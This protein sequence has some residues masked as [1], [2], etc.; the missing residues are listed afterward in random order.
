[1]SERVP[2]SKRLVLVTV[3][4]NVVTHA[5]RVGILLWVL[6]YLLAVKKIPADE[7]AIYVVAM[8]IMQFMPLLTAVLTAGVG[9]YV[10]EAYA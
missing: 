10:T 2:I 1:M 9:R 4:S 3:A 6:R 5:I 8:A 7:Y